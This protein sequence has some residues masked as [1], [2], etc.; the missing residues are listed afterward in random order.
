[1]LLVAFV[2]SFEQL[3]LRT[4]ASSK[5]RTFDNVILQITTNNV[6]SI[7]L[8]SQGGQSLHPLMGLVTLLDDTY[9][10]DFRSTFISNGVFRLT[11]IPKAL[12][13]DGGYKGLDDTE[14]GKYK[15]TALARKVCD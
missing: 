6:L 9:Y 1:M 14:E 3:R 4:K 11:L 5:E 2:Y 15:T 12:V 13:S 8:R 10:D 7:L